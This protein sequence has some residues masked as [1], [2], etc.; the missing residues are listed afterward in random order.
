M[1]LKG[2]VL[3][4]CVFIVAAAVA[5]QLYGSSLDM[6]IA[7]GAVTALVVFLWQRFSDRF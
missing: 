3:V 1:T 2:V 4:L 7:A 5:T 6:L